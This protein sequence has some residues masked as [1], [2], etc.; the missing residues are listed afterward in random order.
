MLCVCMAA[1]LLFSGPMTQKA[2][3]SGS[4]GE[5]LSGSEDGTTYL[6]VR[7]AGDAGNPL[8]L[9]GLYMEETSGVFPRMDLTV[10]K[11]IAGGNE[12]YSATSVYT[13]AR[14]SAGGRIRFRTDSPYISIKAEFPNYYTHASGMGAGKYGFDVYIDTEEGSTY[15]GMVS[16]SAG[17]RPT[18]EAG[19]TGTTE[20]WSYEG[21]VELG[22]A[23]DTQERNVTIY[24]PIA[25]EVSEVQVGVQAGA[26]VAEH[27]IPYESADPI[28]YYGSSI[29]Q[30]GCA[31]S[32][33]KTYVNTV[34]RML[35]RDYLDLG[36]WGSARGEAAFAD[37]IA[38]LDMSMFVFDY[39]H[40]SNAAG[41]RQTHEAFYQK[42]REA[43]S[44]IP[45]VFISRPN[46]QQT[47]YK[48]CREVIKETYNH[49]LEKGENVY[50]I[51]G[52]SFFGYDSSYL[53]DQVHPND[54]GHAAMAEKVGTLLAGILDGSITSGSQGTG[55][56]AEH[57]SELLVYTEKEVLF[58]D[59]F[60]AD[61]LDETNWSG[62]GVE[63]FEITE[64]GTLLGENFATIY[65]GDG[66][67]E[68]KAWMNYKVEAKVKLPASASEAAANIYASVD[69]RRDT[70][71]Y[72]FALVYEPAQERFSGRLYGRDTPVRVNKT[73]SLEGLDIQLDTFYKL[74][75]AVT[76][77]V[78]RCYIDDALV[79]EHV[80][81]SN[82]HPVGAPGISIKTGPAEFDDF[83]VIR[84]SSSQVKYED[85]F[86]T[87]NS[88]SGDWNSSKTVTD[89]KMLVDSGTYLV[90]PDSSG[91]TDYGVEAK[92]TIAE[93][94]G[95][96]NTRV[97][98]IAGR[99]QRSGANF[100]G[101]EFSIGFQNTNTTAPNPYVRLYRRGGGSISNMA[102]K[103]IT[104]YALDMNTEYLLKMEFVGDTINCYIDNNLVI[105][106]ADD[107]Y[108]A[109][110]AGCVVNGYKALVDDFTIISNNAAV[111]YITADDTAY[112]DGQA[113]TAGTTGILAK[114]G[115]SIQVIRYDE[116]AE[117]NKVTKNQVYLIDER[118]HIEQPEGLQDVVGYVGTAIRLEEPTGIRFKSSIA[119]AAKEAAGYTL[120][121]YGTIV[122][123]DS[124][125][126]EGEE[127]LMTTARMQKGVAYDKE[128]GID[129]VFEQSDSAI[130]FTAVLY[131]IK[132]A[133]YQA[134]YVARTYAV[135]QSDT[136][137]SY[138]V[139]GASVTRNL[140]E[141]AK[142]ALADTTAGYD[143]AQRAYLQEIVDTVEATATTGGE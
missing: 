2:A 130:H 112:V 25:Q 94:K 10:A 113:L 33:G 84:L 32:P 21:K 15:C 79:L 46:N 85:R 19:A 135:Y 78:I 126:K 81:N 63:T 49:A 61:A 123:K 109:G 51:D 14:E 122:I 114:P 39:D 97:S 37:Y 16:P 23:G 26:V 139:Y 35:N 99:V 86:D 117:G 66:S 11:E 125:L 82:L 64:A 7:Q 68:A 57:T 127:L 106:V 93:E 107:A 80:D 133:N 110:T 73:I 43:H 60:A 3:A 98:G 101:Y 88:T 59:D 137:D 67:D 30:G 71:A 17:D 102:L 72:E 24:F 34:G 77:N 53:A 105:S 40:N 45:I 36:V 29:T 90:G 136:G 41:L 47:D 141:I 70:C 42:V 62:G 92:V 121:E 8:A 138:T 116:D 65:L 134:D 142:L 22:E 100:Y 119:K 115:S 52:E 31:A 95:T 58:E 9:Y 74:S 4:G 44:D 91:W 131:N 20:P 83:K 12:S 124:L 87:G 143:D 5:G 89:G 55:G 6:D 132:E 54:R 108:Q 50:F 96:N 18:V 140:Y 103:E 28:V 118:G 104:S 111:P 120:Q 75:I 13:H 129:K 48:E 76:D 69:T 56:T 1:S 128:K 38:G 27:A